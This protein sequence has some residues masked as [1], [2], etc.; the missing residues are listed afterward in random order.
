MITSESI[1]EIA[2]A[3]SKAQAQIEASEKDGKNPHFN[4][5]YSSLA[6]VWD[7]CRIPL[8][9]NGLSVCQGLS[10]EDGKIKCT[11]ILLHSSGQFIK[12]ELSMAPQQSTPQAAGSCSTYLRRY[13]LQ[14]IVGVAPDDDDGNEASKSG[15]PGFD[16]QNKV[17]MNAMMAALEKRKVMGTWATNVINAMRGKQMS[18][19][20]A[21]IKRCNTE[22]PDEI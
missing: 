6:A 17:H 1:N 5:R 8:T 2:S 12:S 4:S 22:A 20:E 7:A 19:L 10:N 9:S 16:P 11:T 21:V 15:P 13:S 3:L 14:A 18:E